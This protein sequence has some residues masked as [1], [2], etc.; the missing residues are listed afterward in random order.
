MATN[1]F[2][3][4]PSR[5]LTP[6]AFEFVL[7][8]EIKRAVRSQSYL[9]LVIFEIR[10]E[11]E[12][13]TV[14]ADPEMV[15][16]LVQVVRPEV[17]DSDLLGSTKA[18]LLSLIL[19]GTDHES[20]TGVVDRLVQRLDRHHFPAPLRIAVGV[21]CYPTQAIDATSLRQRAIAHPVV[22]WHREQADVKESAT[23][24]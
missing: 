6:D 20:A 13:M 21:A 5:L 23:R 9:T 19:L 7:D 15:D 10:R 22:S 3:Q 2:V 17:R 16:E 11:W 12:G 8:G 24:H 14:T 18:G 1:A 4:G